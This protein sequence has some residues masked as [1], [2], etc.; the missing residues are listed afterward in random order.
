MIDPERLQLSIAY[1]RKV[2][3]DYRQRLAEI[4]P[5]DPPHWRPNVMGGWAYTLSA[6]GRHTVE[7]YLPERGRGAAQERRRQA[8]A[9]EIRGRPEFIDLLADLERWGLIRPAP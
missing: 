7:Q 5:N 3:A 2:A 1:I 9:A 6:W 8:V 4:K